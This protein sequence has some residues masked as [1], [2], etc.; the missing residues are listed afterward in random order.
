M[1]LFLWEKGIHFCARLS[2][3]TWDI[4]KQFLA[5]GLSQQVIHLDPIADAQKKCRELGLSIKS[6]PLRLVRIH[7]EDAQEPIVP[8]CGKSVETVLQ[9]FHANIFMH[10]LTAILAFLVH[11]HIEKSVQKKLDYKINWTQALA[12]MRNCGM[13]LFFRKR[14]VSLMKKLHQ[15]FLGNNSAIRK[16]RQFPRNIQPRKKFLPFLI[17][18]FLNLMTLACIPTECLPMLPPIQCIR[19]L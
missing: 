12:K 5:S 8:L 11:S 4:A 19:K 13:V 7:L 3:S 18:Q 16:G 9:D 17:S 1:F 6:V 14:M 15:L 2:L 10:N